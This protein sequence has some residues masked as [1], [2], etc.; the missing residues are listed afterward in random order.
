MVI[1]LDRAIAMLKVAAPAAAIL[2]L[3]DWLPIFD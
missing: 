3:S 2:A 1:I